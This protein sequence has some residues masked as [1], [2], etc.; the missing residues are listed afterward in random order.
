MG[1]LRLCSPKS[2]SMGIPRVVALRKDTWRS[3]KPKGWGWVMSESG[4]DDYLISSLQLS[5]EENCY[6]APH[7]TDQETKAQKS[8]TAYPRSL[9]QQVITAALLT[10][11]DWSR[12]VL[13]PSLPMIW[14]NRHYSPIRQLLQLSVYKRGNC[15]SWSQS[16]GRLRL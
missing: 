8:A 6:H 15:G 1:S 11:T 12:P 13:C 16:S 5:D 2:Q 14:C 9:G 4:G 7:F 3:V 10:R